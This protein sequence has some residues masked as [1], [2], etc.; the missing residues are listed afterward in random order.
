[1]PSSEQLQQRAASLLALH[2]PGDPVVL[3][4]V[5]DAWSANLA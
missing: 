3:P 2:R 1:M 4:T 5:W